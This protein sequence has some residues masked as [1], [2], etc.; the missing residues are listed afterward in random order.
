MGSQPNVTAN[1][2]APPSPSRLHARVGQ[3]F[4]GDWPVYLRACLPV[5][6]AT[7]ANDINDLGSR[8]T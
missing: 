5:T 7:L 2:G 6:L 8:D 4:P 3:A 1:L